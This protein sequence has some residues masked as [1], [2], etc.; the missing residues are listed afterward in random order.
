[1]RV[2]PLDDPVAEV[3]SRG[4][5]HKLSLSAAEDLGVGLS[6]KGAKPRTR[7]R[8][9]GGGVLH[10]VNHGNVNSRASTRVAVSVGVC[11]SLP[12]AIQHW[13]GGKC[14][15]AIEVL[16]MSTITQKEGEKE[17]FHSR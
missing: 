17:R 7:C 6:A 1:M 2:I 14:C 10:A 5:C 4:G 11:R 12:G 16:Q 3:A 9:R 15:V 13:G 8:L